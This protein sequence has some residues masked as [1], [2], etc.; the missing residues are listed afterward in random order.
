MVTISNGQQAELGLLFEFIRFI[1]LLFVIV[2]FNDSR[3]DVQL[4]AE[5]GLLS[6]FHGGVRVPGS[7]VENMAHQQRVNLNAAGKARIAQAVAAAVPHNCSL[8]L[9][10]GTRAK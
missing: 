1:F 6:R 8:M 9:N 7:T 2:R 10:I 5:E 3:R 4:L